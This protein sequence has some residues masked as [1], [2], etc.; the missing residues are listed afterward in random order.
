MQGKSY[1][2][3]E[4]DIWALGIL[5]YTIVY[6]E[7]PFYNVDEI[8]DHPL[9]VPYLPFSESCIDLIRGMLNR[10]VEKRLVIEEVMNHPWMTAEDSDEEIE[11][12]TSTVVPK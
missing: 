11:L 12:P 2:G 9:R 6:K 8:L 4:Q 3:K 5:L 7:N 1:N 10:T